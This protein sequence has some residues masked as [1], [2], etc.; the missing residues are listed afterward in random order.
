MQVNISKDWLYGYNTSHK[1]LSRLGKIGD[2]TVKHFEKIFVGEK[3][4]DFFIE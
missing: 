2:A 3:I 1:L 4:F